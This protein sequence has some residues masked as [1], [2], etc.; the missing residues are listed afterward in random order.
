MEVKV[1][2]VFTGAEQVGADR[3]ALLN[4]HLVGGT[5]SWTSFAERFTAACAALGVYEAERIL[6]V[7]DGAAAIPLD[8]GAQLSVTRS[9]C[10]TGIT[11]RSSCAS[12]WAASTRK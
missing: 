12:V 5:G 10:W 7:S 8:P 11:S 1:G 9:S 6:F 4:R 3:R 2:L